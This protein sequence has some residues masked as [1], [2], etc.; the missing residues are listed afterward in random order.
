[1]NSHSIGTDPE[2]NF[3]KIAFPITKKHFHL[4]KYPYWKS[5][6]LYLRAATNVMMSENIVFSNQKCY[7]DK[8]M[9]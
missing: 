8:S 7:F 5:I 1:M 3:N 9:H 6:G 2:R 4:P